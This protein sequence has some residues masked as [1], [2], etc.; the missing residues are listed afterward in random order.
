MAE[1]AEEFTEETFGQCPE[2]GGAMRVAGQD[3]MRVV[4]T[5]RILG[6]SKALQRQSDRSGFATRLTCENG[7]TYWMLTEDVRTAG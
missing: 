3:A 5:G 7:H 4:D 2:C 1:E 6:D